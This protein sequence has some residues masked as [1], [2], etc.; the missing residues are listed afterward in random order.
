MTDE[1]AF[2]RALL[3]RPEDAAPRLVFADW[4]LERGREAEADRLRGWDGFDDTPY[5]AWA[6]YLGRTGRPERAEFV[7]VQCS[8]EALERFKMRDDATPNGIPVSATAA[9]LNGPADTLRIEFADATGTPRLSERERQLWQ[10]HGR[11][12]TA[13]LPG[14]FVCLNL[15]GPVV[16]RRHPEDDNLK[17]QAVRGIIRRV[18][19]R[20]G[21]WQKCADDLVAG[22]PLRSITLTRWP[23]TE[24]DY[25]DGEGYHVFVEGVGP[26]VGPVY[27]PP[28]QR[29]GDRE[30]ALLDAYKRRWPDLRFHLSVDFVL[31]QVFEEMD[32]ADWWQAFRKS[33]EETIERATPAGPQLASP[34]SDQDQL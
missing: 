8:L 34:P 26:G 4:L 9:S 33:F 10:A 21:F 30:A 22:W 31:D 16:F 25:K 29:P 20:P 11:A 32:G 6:D 14:E 17:F 3:L 7:R 19:C 12:W 23:K 27:G 5:L 2:W 18:G 24:G 1:D 13:D 15:H 28:G